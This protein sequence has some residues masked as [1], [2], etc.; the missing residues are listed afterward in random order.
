MRYRGLKLNGGSRHRTLGVRGIA[1]F[2]LQAM[3]VGAGCLALCQTPTPLSTENSRLLAY[4][5]LFF[6]V[7]WLED[8]GNQLVSQ[9]KNGAYANSV[10]QRDYGLTEAEQAKLTVVAA[11]WRDKFDAIQNQAKPLVAAGQ[12]STSSPALQELLAARLRVTSD[13]IDQLRGALGPMRFA[14]MDALVTKPAAV[15]A[16][17]SRAVAVGGAQRERRIQ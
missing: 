16:S 13:H 17:G 2:C 7:M 9:G 11:D 3:L 1:R 5:K 14:A 12:K 8:K 4:D 10:L 15:S 6:R